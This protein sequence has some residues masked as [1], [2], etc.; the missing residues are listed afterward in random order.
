MEPR[1]SESSE[2]ERAGAL[3]AD[4]RKGAAGN[5]EASTDA[6]LV[7]ATLAGDRNAFDQ[8]VRRYQKQAIALAYQRLGNV[9]DAQEVTQ[10]AFIKAFSQLSSLNTPEAFGGWLLRTVS[11]L[12]LNFRRG[13]RL[14]RN[15]GLDESFMTGDLNPPDSG[16]GGGG[17][18][19]SDH[20]IRSTR[21]SR[22]LEDAELSERRRW[23]MAQLP[24][25]QRLAIEM[26]AI[27][28]LPQKQVADALECSVEAVKWHVFQGRKRLKELLKD[29]L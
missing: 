15:P 1:L 12:A 23:A 17:G 20:S 24:E 29:L 11:N 6:D 22:A 28:G 18:I 9:D 27:N 14:R 25:K 16:G 13:R 7:R 4:G 21:P 26:F 10:D 19:Q 5:T 2:H 8:L 3:A